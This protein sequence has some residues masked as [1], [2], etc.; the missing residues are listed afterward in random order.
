MRV[1]V[2]FQPAREALQRCVKGQ[3]AVNHYYLALVQV[4]QALMAGLSLD[5]FGTAIWAPRIFSRISKCHYLSWARKG[6][7]CM[8]SW[9]F[10]G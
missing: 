9:R 4:R 8:F 10:N 3:S 6:F 7:M 1:G 2:K 5:P